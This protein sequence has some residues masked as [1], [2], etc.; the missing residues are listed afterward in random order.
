MPT[1]TKFED[2][3]VW[4][5]ARDIVNEVYTLTNSQ[6]FSQDYALND[7]IRRSA[8]G[9]MSNIAEGF[10][11]GSDKQFARYLKIAKGSAGECRAQC[12][13][14]LDQDYISKSEFNN[15]KDKLTKCSGK[16]SRLISYLNGSTNQVNEL[17]II[18]DT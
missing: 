15:C 11:S 2:L 1:I 7:Q 13:I 10:E 14:A 18:Y 5:L 12:Y 8:I 17:E 4:Q 9:I 16:L 6:D 3:E